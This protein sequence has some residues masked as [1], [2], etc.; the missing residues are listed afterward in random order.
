MN[1]FGKL[2]TL[3]SFGESHGQAVGGVLDGFPAGIRIDMDFLQRTLSHRSPMQQA[4]SGR[5]EPDRVELLSGVYEGVSLGSPIAFL[6][7]NQDAHSGDYAALKHLFRPAHADD[8]YFHKYGVRD[9]RGGGRASARETAVRVAGGALAEMFLKQLC[10][11]QGASEIEIH[12]YT[13][14]IGTVCLPDE[15]ENTLDMARIYTCPT[16]CPHEDTDRKMQEV[17]KQC[18]EEKDSTGGVVRCVVKN[19]PRN[20]GEPVY[21]KLSARLA[22]AMLGINAARGFEIGMGFDAAAQKGSVHNDTWL[23]GGNTAHNHAG[24]VR[25]GISTGEALTFNVAFKPIPT[26]MREQTLLREDGKL[27]NLTLTGRHDVCCVPRAVSVVKAMT[28]LVLA[29]FTLLDHCSRL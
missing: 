9:E 4:G 17:L 18:R 6:I 16:R 5:K 19:M 27:E 28:A 12:A 21:D 13:K 25:G 20:L 3:T 22:G 1:T 11:K 15:A 2:L 26:L 24:G 8:T 29:D 14:Q 7:G 10:E 23:E